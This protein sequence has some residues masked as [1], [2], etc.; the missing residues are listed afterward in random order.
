MFVCSL[1]VFVLLTGFIIY[2]YRKSYD[3]P[4]NQIRSKYDTIIKKFEIKKYVDD[5]TMNQQ[6]IY[7]NFYITHTC[8]IT[9]RN[10]NRLH[11]GYFN[12][13]QPN[14]SK[15]VVS[16][17]HLRINDGEINI[18]GLPHETQTIQSADV[19]MMLFFEQHVALVAEDICKFRKTCYKWNVGRLTYLPMETTN[20]T[21]PN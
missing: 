5:V 2:N 18:I 19:C 21:T 17:R 1:C 10:N 20:T 14:K 3:S 13:F 6:I 16:G 8:E 9:I 15:L 12:F 11:H 7:G 4:T